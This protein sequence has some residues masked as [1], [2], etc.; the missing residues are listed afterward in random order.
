MI[1]RADVVMVAV[2][3]PFVAVALLLAAMQMSW[4]LLVAFLFP[5]G[6]VSLVLFGLIRSKFR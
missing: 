1:S 5:V 4:I 2:V 6:F 3:G